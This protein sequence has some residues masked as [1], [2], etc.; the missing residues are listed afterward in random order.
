MAGKDYAG[1]FF[2]QLG[3]DSN[4]KE[5]N[6]IG[7]ET[8]GVVASIVGGSKL[9]S[10]RYLEINKVAKSTGLG[11]N[12]IKQVGI[13]FDQLGASAEVGY[14]LI[15]N[16]SDKVKSFKNL[17]ETSK[18]L[19]MLGIE[20]ADSVGGLIS[21]LRASAVNNPEMFKTQAP[22]VG[23]STT[24]IAYLSQEQGDLQRRRDFAKENS[25]NTDELIEQSEE[26][27]E[28][29]GRFMTSLKSVADNLIQVTNE[30]GILKF[31][32]ENP[33]LAIAGG[34]GAGAGIL[35]AK[36][37]LKMGGRFAIRNPAL[38]GVGLGF[39]AEK[40]LQNSDAYQNLLNKGA[41]LDYFTKINT[42]LGFIRQPEDFS[43]KQ[44]TQNISISVP[45]TSDIVK[46]V[47]E[48]GK[49]N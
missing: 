6:K 12:Y 5:F 36:S 29:W 25:K 46:V 20:Q 11:S 41:G 7:A 44:V 16:L 48:L 2:Y 27:N 23:L 33:E 19:Q 49:G 37:I 9:L 31:G 1:S 38:A 45:S 43:R 32:E 8:A 47:D 42:S 17:G 15:S 13:E 40:L 14:N 10:Q 18:P 34:V 24:E 39:G 30:S 22:R 26:L 4:L 35:K 21:Q 28:S 3:I